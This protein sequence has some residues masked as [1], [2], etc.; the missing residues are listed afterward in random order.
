M[1]NEE[2]HVF[3]SLI[4]TSKDADIYLT[5]KKHVE[6]LLE[7]KKYRQ[8]FDLIFEFI[9]CFDKKNISDFSEY[10]LNY[11]KHPIKV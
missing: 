3:F 7:Q 1:T 8:A 11:M 2:L 6:S 5:Y 9:E 4:Q 10:M